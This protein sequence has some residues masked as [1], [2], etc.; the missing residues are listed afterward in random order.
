M[1]KIKQINNKIYITHFVYTFETYSYKDFWKDNSAPFYR[2]EYFSLINKKNNPTFKNIVKMPEYFL[3]VLKFALYDHINNRTL[4]IKKRHI[5]EGTYGYMDLPNGITISAMAVCHANDNFSRKKGK[6]LV[7]KRLNNFS[8]FINKKL[9]EGI[10]IDNLPC[11]I[12]KKTKRILHI[13]HKK[14]ENNDS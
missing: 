6:E 3:Y 2:N 12:S 8:E 9:K 4:D 1:K 14:E 11:T 13:N 7:T 10:S 5:V